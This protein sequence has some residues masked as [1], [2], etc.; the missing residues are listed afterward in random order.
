MRVALAFKRYDVDQFLDDI[1][2]EQY[3]E[4]ANFFTLEAQGW[5]ATRLLI[6]R[7]SF[8]LAQTHSAKRLKEKT[9]D[10]KLGANV[11]SAA[12]EAA[13]WEALSIRS[14]IAAE[15]QNER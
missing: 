3:V 7:L 10:I 5:Q 12:T 13:Q 1:D 2:H 15:L 8:M 4:W 6:Q 9:Y 11:Y 14:E